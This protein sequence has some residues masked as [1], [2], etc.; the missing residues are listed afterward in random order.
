[1]AYVEI[2]IKNDSIVE[3]LEWFRVRLEDGDSWVKYSSPSSIFFYI[4][5][6]DC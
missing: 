3:P 6:N 2:L 4:E 5:D 1:M